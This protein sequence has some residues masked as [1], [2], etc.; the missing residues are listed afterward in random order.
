MN[1][2]SPQATADL[3]NGIEALLTKTKS[4]HIVT[5]FEGESLITNMLGLT[6]LIDPCMRRYSYVDGEYVEVPV[7]PGYLD[8]EF[9]EALIFPG[10]K[11]PLEDGCRLIWKRN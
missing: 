11:E 1:E 8:A 10:G 7:G 5:S 3:R 2:S 6:V 9:E 4:R